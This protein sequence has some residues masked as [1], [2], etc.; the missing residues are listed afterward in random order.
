MTQTADT[1]PYQSDAYAELD[2][3]ADVDGAYVNDATVTVSLETMSGSA[4]TG[5]QNLAASYVASSNGKYRALIPRT[6]DVRLGQKYRC[7]AT[8]VRGGLQMQFVQLVQVERY[9]A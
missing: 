1:L 5:A 8:A 7:V 4:V 6:A 3:L 2:A 9:E